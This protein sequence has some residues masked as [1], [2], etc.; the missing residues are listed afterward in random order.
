MALRLNRDKILSKSTEPARKI[1]VNDNTSTIEE[2]MVQPGYHILFDVLR[3]A[4]DQAQLGK[5]K[6]RH[7]KGDTPFDRQPILEIARMVGLGSAAGQVIK[8]TQEAT[9]L[10]KDRAIKELLGAINYAAA[11]I[12]LLEEQED[13]E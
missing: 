4:L 12:I 10:P 3:E 13:S 6:E 2:V 1:I 7:Q 8:K 11:C 5:G 9:R